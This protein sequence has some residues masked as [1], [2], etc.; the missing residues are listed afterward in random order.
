MLPPPPHTHRWVLYQKPEFKGEKIALDE[1]DIEL[2]NP[3]GP[4][5]EEQQ[6]GH[7]EEE[8]KEQSEETGDEQTESKPARRFVI[9]SLR[10]VVRVR[11]HVVCLLTHA[12]W[13]S[14]LN[15]SDLI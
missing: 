1:G 7:E 9:G 6:N 13:S 3:F 11:Y 12:L 14:E 2:T 15:L 8:K 5:E 4:L 10:R